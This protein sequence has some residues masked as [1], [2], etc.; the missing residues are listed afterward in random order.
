MKVYLYSDRAEK[1][2]KYNMHL[3]PAG[4][5][6]WSGHSSEMPKAWFERDGNPKRF[7]VNFAFG[8][9]ELPDDLARYALDRGLVHKTRALR[10]V[11]QLFDAA[12][13]AVTE[14]F[15]SE[16]RSVAVNAKGE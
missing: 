2:A 6:A 8:A 7:E 11:R 5:T 12:G 15:D 13:N 14:L 16:G 9:A 10:K 1:S 4:D 3:C